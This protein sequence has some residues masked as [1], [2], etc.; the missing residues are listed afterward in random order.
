MVAAC[1]YGKGM[2]GVLVFFFGFMLMSAWYFALYNQE[3]DKAKYDPMKFQ[4]K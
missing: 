3:E 4:K 2:M 1:R